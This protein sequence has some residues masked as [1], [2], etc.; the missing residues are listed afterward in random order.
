MTLQAASIDWALDFVANH[1]D[2]D[3]FPRLP[4]MEALLQKKPD[5]IKLVENKT[6]NI[7]T[8][9][10][11]ACRRFIV[12][13]DEIS[14]RQATQLDPQDSIILSAIVHQFGDKI[15]SRRLPP[16]I[17]FSYRF[18]PTPS[19]GLYG[20]TSAW[21]DF[22]TKAQ[23]L[24]H[25]CKNVLYCDIADFYNQVYHHTVENQLIA[26]G[27]PNQ[28]IKW[29]IALLESTTA[30]VSRGVPIGPHAV[31]LIAEAT[32]IPI[33][34]SL[35][36]NGIEFIRY[37]DDIIVFCNSDKDA[38][39]ALAQIASILDKQQRLML[40]RH[41]TKFYN[42]TEFRAL[43]ADM[44]QDRPISQNEASLLSII[45]RYSGG[46]PY[47]TITYNQISPSDWRTIS[48]QTIRS[49]IEDY[50][51]S[52]NVDYIR[53]RWFYRRLSQI[54]HP[55]AIEVSLQHLDKLGPCFANICFYL[56]SVQ[57]VDA[58][59]WKSIGSQL[60]RL[61]ELDEV[62]QNEYFRL[63]ILSLFSR[64]V[65]INHFSSLAKLY[66]ASDPFVRREVLLAAKVNNAFDWIHDYK[67]SFHLMDPWQKTAFL[68]C[69]SG[70]PADEKKYFIN[71]WTFE[72]PFEQIL[73]KWSKEV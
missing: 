22:W 6:L 62:K 12:P 68:Y 55:G 39:S 14:Y 56:A 36:Q 17:I 53:L 54:G 43:C 3:L 65:H 28:A 45:K 9:L 41:K 64:N 7:N 70:L 8:F 67:E 73:A 57:S 16:D 33:D 24:S 42:P 10:P 61:L 1:S 5:F 26:S 35:Q 27:L 47:R 13:K 50:L 29:V 34:N 66:Q 19:D 32:L 2:G 63:S 23:A 72:R 20:N 4:E 37:A 46:N 48:E 59:S 25:R 38:K 60:L 31:H 18:K 52:S 49:V 30:G 71:R 51:S 15:E 40:Q 21:N 11:G 58:A 44:I 69:V